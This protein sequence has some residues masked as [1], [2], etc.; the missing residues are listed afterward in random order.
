MVTKQGLI[1]EP[2]TNLRYCQK[3]VDTSESLFQKATRMNQEC[4]RP[5][6]TCSS[7]AVELLAC[8]GCTVDF[9]YTFYGLSLRL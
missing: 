6:I 5:T 1:L 9:S 7:L 4:H 2:F 8:P 3:A